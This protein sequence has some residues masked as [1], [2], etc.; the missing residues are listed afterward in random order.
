MRS[1]S[2]K[3]PSR[4]WE[5]I[6]SLYECVLIARNDVTKQQVEGIVESIASQLETDGGAMIKREYWG[7]RSLAYRIKKN[8]KGHYMLLGLDA[9]PAFV[10]EMERQ[11][12]LNEDILR[13]MTLGVNEIEEGPSALLSRAAEERDRNFRGPKP[14]GRFDSGRRRSFGEREEFRARD[15]LSENL[16]EVPKPTSAVPEVV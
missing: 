13:F 9:K 2:P 10:N 4:L 16:E 14:A 1:V 6:L 15:T 8:R 7:L 5:Y 3:L 12:R 11:L